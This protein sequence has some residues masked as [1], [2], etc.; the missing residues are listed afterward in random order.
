[1][2][3]E[4][5]KTPRQLE[6]YFKGASNHRRIAILLLVAERPGV[7]VEE[8]TEALDANFKTI[9]SHTKRLVDAGLLNKR[10]RV[11]KVEH[12]LSP[13]GKIFVKFIKSFQVTK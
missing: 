5:R 11:H 4:K 9:S 2:A 1:M 7:N 3:R 6:K 12:R 8:I 13:Y 10:Y